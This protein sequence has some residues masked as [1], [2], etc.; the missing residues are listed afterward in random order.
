[1]RYLRVVIDKVLSPEEKAR[2]I[3]KH[4]YRLVDDKEEKIL[5][6]VTTVKP[7]FESNMQYVGKQTDS[8]RHQ[9]LENDVPASIEILQSPD[10]PKD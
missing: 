6:K 10:S 3:K 1:M 7:T 5:V 9:S 8:V 2:V 4:K